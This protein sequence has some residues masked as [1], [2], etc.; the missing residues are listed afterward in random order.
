MHLEKPDWLTQ[1][2]RSYIGQLEKRVDSHVFMNDYRQWLITKV[3]ELHN[4]T[5]EILKTSNGL[6]Y[7][8]VIRPMFEKEEI[9][10]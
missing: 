9:W 5:L 8:D 1:G 7:L 10:L 2:E 6:N 4:K 3:E